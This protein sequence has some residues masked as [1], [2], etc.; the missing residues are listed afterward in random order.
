MLYDLCE[1]Y[2][3]YFNNLVK[4][5]IIPDYSEDVFISEFNNTDDLHYSYRFRKPTEYKGHLI[6]IGIDKYNTKYNVSVGLS[7]LV[8][9]GDYVSGCVAVVIDDDT[10]LTYDELRDIIYKEINQ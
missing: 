9:L 4:A 10:R 8:E 1:H 6:R 7:G 2:D 5:L 3:E